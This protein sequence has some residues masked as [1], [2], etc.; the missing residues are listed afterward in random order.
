[1]AA[2]SVVFGC[3]NRGYG[4]ECVYRSFSLSLWVAMGLNLAVMK[5]SYD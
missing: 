5:V 2:D 3:I 1:M 4:G